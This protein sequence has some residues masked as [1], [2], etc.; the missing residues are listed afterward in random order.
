MKTIDTQNFDALAIR[1]ASPEDILSWSYGEVTKPETINY[2]T[3]RSERYGLFD[4]RIFGPEKDYECYCGKYKR[5]RYKGVICEKCGVEVTKSI[6]RRERM[7]HIELASP[8]A[9]IW[10]LRDIPSRIA[11]ILGSSQSDVE[12]VIYFSAYIVTHVNEAEKELVLKNLDDEFKA[13]IKSANDDET[14]DR[15]H[16]LLD[17]AKSEISEIKEWSILDEVVYH[18]YIIK[19]GSCFEAKIG[20]EAIH[21]IFKSINLKD[22]EAKLVAGLED[23]GALEKEK[24]EKRL[25]LIRSLI[26]SNTRPEWMFLTVLPV[27]PAGIRPMVAL[28][29]GRYA[30]SDVND[31]YRR[32][33]NRNIRLKKLLEIEAPE[34]ILRNEKRILQEAVDAL[35]DNSKRSGEAAM[36]LTGQKR[37]LKSIADNIKSKQGLF[38]GNLLGKRVDYSA[39]SVIVVGPDLSID[40]CGL[41]KK[42]ALELFKPFVIAKLIARELSYNIRGANKLIEDGIDEVWE[43]LEKEIQNKYVLLNRAPTLHRLGVQ[44]FRPKLIEGNAIQLHPLVCEAFNADFDGDQMAVHLPLSQLAQKE[45]ETLMAANKNLLRPGSGDSIVNPRM[46]MTLGVYWMTSIVD[47]AKGEGKYF[48]SPNEAITSKDFGITDTR[49]KVLV[50]PTDTDKYKN[51]EGKM[52]ETSI[53]RLYFN[54]VLPKDYPFINEQIDKKKM[55]KILADV[56]D[57]YTTEEVAI[58]LDKIKAFGYK[59]ATKSGTTWSLTSV[60]SPEVKKEIID[61][62]FDK[63]VSIDD[64]YNE[65]LLSES[66]KYD[67]TVNSWLDAKKELEVIIPALLEKN[68]PVADLIISGARGTMSQL[69]Q[70]AGMKGIIVNNSGRQM[71]FPV[72]SSYIEGLTPIEYFI[73]TYGARKGNTD[74]A[75]KT[76]QAGYLT[77]KLVDVSQDTIVR[78]IDCGTER[79]KVFRRQNVFGKDVSLA[80]QIRGRILAKDIDQDGLL[81][82]KGHLLLDVDAHAI[83]DSNIQEVAVFTPLTCESNIGICQKCYGLDMGRNKLV[84]MGEAV[85]IVAAQAIGEPGTQLTMRTFHAGGVAGADITQGLPRVEE[86]F[87]RR[88]PKAEASISEWNGE[89]TDIRQEGKRKVI[90]ILLNEGENRKKGKMIDYELAFRRTPIV[91]KG[92]KITKGQI[93]SDGSVNLEKLF[94]FA[95]KEITEEYV[96]AE[97]LKVYDLQ[98]ASINRKHVEI[99]IRQM[100]SRIRITNAG[101]S[102]FVKGDLVEFSKFN[103]EN[104]ALKAEGKEL[105]EGKRLILSIKEVAI[106]TA[107]WLSAAS[108]QNTTKVL[109][110]AS[111]KGQVDELRGL[112][113]NV[114]LGRIIPAGTGIRGV[115]GMEEEYFDVHED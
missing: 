100:M 33:L 28:D 78:E 79:H 10:F 24:I 1:I 104:I 30:A 27:I 61:R 57:R 103:I 110:N 54:S 7:G 35:I 77:R 102:K 101:Q 48:G 68:G 3:G 89:V 93:L 32:V 114:I 67:M 65:G 97:I 42:M 15:L 38:R 90:S 31:L 13:K 83:E 17:K 109:I 63:V 111:L 16:E 26:N 8:V 74:T 106:T 58:I 59:Y 6:V 73:T 107:S 12:K 56:F 5:I 71:D 44:A 19:Y 91:K 70:L 36:S 2:R 92:D 52:F 113:E 18:R 25:F 34:V 11:T 60:T 66:E 29:G 115:E 82:K 84:D 108:F 23:A 76:A 72:L 112:K 105:A 50:R 14:R 43:I 86:I 69:N 99:I 94:E 47:G 41:P 80:K 81:Y 95:G 45:A 39:R 98:G 22:L 9:H 88:E 53:G 4:E 20:A 49:A 85:G 62:A 75:L 37:V 51:F 87:E 40:E 21:N 96:V 64:N 46:D 55:N